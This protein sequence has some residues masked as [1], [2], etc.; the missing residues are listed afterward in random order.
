MKTIVEGHIID[1]EDCIVLNEG[2][3][4][5][6]GYYNEEIK[7]K[8]GDLEFSYI[9]SKFTN[10]SD[11]IAPCEQHEDFEF[12]DLDVNNDEGYKIE[13]L[14]E[15]VEEIEEQHNYLNSDE[16]LGKEDEIKQLLQDLEYYN[17]L[18]PEDTEIFFEEDNIGIDANSNQDFNFVSTTILKDDYSFY[19][20]EK[21]YENE[22]KGKI[23]KDDVLNF[24]L[25]SY[26]NFINPAIPKL[27][28][29]NR[30]IFE[31][32]DLFKYIKC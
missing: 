7:Y 17:S 5:Q 24:L 25:A 2:E 20:I 6:H 9:S 27:I 18:I 15:E 16:I 14:K 12:Y 8:I 31:D 1:L 23:S 10:I 30:E 21:S 29:D 11:I 28:L 13:K 19:V 32:E 22:R 4:P 3:Q 26:S